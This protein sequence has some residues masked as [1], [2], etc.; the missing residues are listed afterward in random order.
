M[1][2]LFIDGFDHYRTGNG[3]VT[4]DQFTNLW[5][6]SSTVSYNTNGVTGGAITFQ[7]GSGANIGPVHNLDTPIS[8]IG[9]GFHLSID[10]PPQSV[11][12]DVFSLQSNAGTDVFTLTLSLGGGLLQARQGGIGGTLLQTAATQFPVNIFTHLEVKVV[13]NGG[14]TSTY[15]VR[16][17]GVTVLSGTFNLTVNIGRVRLGQKPS[18]GGNYPQMYYDNFFIWDTTG[19]T[20]NSFLGER[21]VYTL[22]PDADTADADWVLSSGTDGFA[23]LDNIP[24]S[25]TD[26]IESTAIGDTSSFGMTQLPST[27]IVVIGVQTTVRGLK[28]G[29]A[30]STLAVGP[31]GFT[32][33][34]IPLVQD[35][36][37]RGYDIFEVNPATGLAWL[38]SEVNDLEVQIERIS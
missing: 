34:P 36:S 13:N 16:Q 23:L 4:Q 24:P 32:G 38:P 35:A 12:G 19:T 5:S 1:A 17:N 9:V 29:T 15:E 14:T 31:T 6:V 30:A 2:L 7:V 26:Y 21:N 18:G 3:I 33:D 25:D 10:T 8:A 37:T 28:T 22:L 11:T 20:S 27:D